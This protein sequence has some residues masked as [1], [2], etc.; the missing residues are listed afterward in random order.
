MGAP[1]RRLEKMCASK[2][3]DGADATS[4]FVFVWSVSLCHHRVGGRGSREGRNS[5]IRLG[6]K[7]L[8]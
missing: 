1:Y 3:S 5:R 7:I 4:E 6:L 2:V 8:S